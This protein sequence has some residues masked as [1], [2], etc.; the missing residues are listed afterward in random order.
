MTDTASVW[1]DANMRC[2]ATVPLSHRSS[3][4]P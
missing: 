1:V 3:L 2:N 4:L